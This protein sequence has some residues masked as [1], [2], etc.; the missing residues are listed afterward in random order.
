MGDVAR[1]ASSLHRQ[2]RLRDVS[3][4]PLVDHVTNLSWQNK[5]AK[6]IARAP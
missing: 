1:S 6:H 4:K 2:R 3:W 5:E